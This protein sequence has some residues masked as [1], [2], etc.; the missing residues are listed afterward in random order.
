VVTFRIESTPRFYDQ[1]SGDWKDGDPLFLACNVWRQAAENVA[2]SLLMRTRRAA[3][4]I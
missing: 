1:A 3:I 2:E 4:G